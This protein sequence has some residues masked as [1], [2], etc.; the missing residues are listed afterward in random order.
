M[1]SRA[2]RIALAT[3][4]DLP[5]W[6]KDD[7][8]FFAALESRGVELS[9][10][11]WSEPRDWSQ[12]DACLV[13]T[14]W[15]YQ[16]SSDAF[17]L[18]VEEVSSQSRLL[19]PASVI[20]WNIQKSYLRELETAGARCVPTEW[21]EA[22]TRCD[23]ST[24][25]RERGWERGFIKPVIGANARETYRFA[26]GTPELETAQREVERLLE[27]ESLMLQPY[28]DTVERQ[29]EVSVVYFDGDFSH[30]VRK[31]PKTGDYRVQDDWGAHDEPWAPSESERAEARALLEYTHELCSPDE[32]LLYARLDFLF[33][34]DGSLAVNEVELI[35]PSLFFRHDERAADRLARALCRRIAT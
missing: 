19:N 17:L 11:A 24:T 9:H 10:P 3:S 35:E 13:R 18:W 4:S 34:P 20:R 32:P 28:L 1:S 25:L 2:P 5:D 26:V 16:E 22:G 21:F 30:G 23:L 31:I 33:M 27:T 6:E 15:D 14:T 8:P 12:F 29:G 7:T